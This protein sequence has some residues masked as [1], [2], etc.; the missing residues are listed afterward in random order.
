MTGRGTWFKVA[1]WRVICVAFQIHK[2]LLRKEFM[3]VCVC[4]L[5]NG[6]ISPNSSTLNKRQKN[7]KINREGVTRL[8]C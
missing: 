1:T 2:T 3:C 5:A 8:P 6:N 7:N 4:V